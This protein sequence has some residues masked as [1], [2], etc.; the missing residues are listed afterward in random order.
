MVENM[1]DVAKLKIELDAAASGKVWLNGVDISDSLTSIAFR[2]GGGGLTEVT[3]TIHAA[4]D[5]NIEA[6]LDQIALKKLKPEVRTVRTADGRVL[7][8]RSRAAN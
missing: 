6:R 5:A 4:V 8:V 3:L 7:P 2:A 1:A